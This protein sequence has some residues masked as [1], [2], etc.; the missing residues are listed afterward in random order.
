MPSC[1]PLLILYSLLSSF[2]VALHV[3]DMQLS[4]VPVSGSPFAL[5]PAPS[6]QMQTL[7]FDNILATQVWPSARECASV[8]EN[9]VERTW[10]VVEVG[11]GPGY[12]SLTAASLGCR[13]V[14]TDIS[15][16]ALDLVRKAAEEQGFGDRIHTRR[17]DLTNRADYGW[18]DD[19][20]LVLIS[21]VFESNAVARATAEFT[22]CL[23]KTSKTRVWVFAQQDRAQR[24]VFLQELKNLG[25][26]S[27]KDLRW[28]R[29]RDATIPSEAQV[30][31]YDVDEC[32]VR[33]Q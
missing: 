5:V 6:T 33:Y 26:G 14:A 20:D 22:H 8:L 27:L 16:F 10:V 25:E 31:L 7:G 32:L 15:S 28:E 29:P 2:S 23:Q 17:F 24:E 9:S 21:D 11:C 19:V 13:T 4:R 30:Y 12:P 3:S 1:L 18:F